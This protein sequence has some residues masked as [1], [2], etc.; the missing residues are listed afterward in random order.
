MTKDIRD[1]VDLQMVIDSYLPLSVIPL[2]SFKISKDCKKGRPNL[3]NVI[4]D[5]RFSLSYI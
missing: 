4:L 2:L 3:S 1:F 5:I